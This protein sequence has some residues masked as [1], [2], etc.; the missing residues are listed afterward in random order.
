MRSANNM[1]LS[2]FHAAVSSMTFVAFVCSD[3]NYKLHF[4]N[5]SLVFD[6]LSFMLSQQHGVAQLENQASE[7]ENFYDRSTSFS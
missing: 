2:L 5:A 7:L 3:H 6:N 1:P 4:H